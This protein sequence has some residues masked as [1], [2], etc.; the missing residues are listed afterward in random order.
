[1]PWTWPLDMRLG[2]VYIALL[3]F[4]TP[5]GCSGGA[6]WL[7]AAPPERACRVQSER[8]AR[9]RSGSHALGRGLQLGHQLHKRLC[10]Q[11]LLEVD[12]GKPPDAIQ[13][14]TV[15][16]P[17]DEAKDIE[18]VYKRDV[19]VLFAHMIVYSV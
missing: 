5:L 17:F 10:V 9:R 3:P 18:W 8:R 15:E 12:D 14:A 13:A 19:P 1:M 2:Q 11:F 6:C 7:K 16:C 4:S